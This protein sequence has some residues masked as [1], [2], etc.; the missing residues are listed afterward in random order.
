MHAE[1]DDL[2]NTASRG[3]TSAP[4]SRLRQPERDPLLR[5]RHEQPVGIEH[6]SAL[7]IPARICRKYFCRKRLSAAT[8]PVIRQVTAVLF[9]EIVW[10]AAAPDVLRSPEPDGA[11]RELVDLR[12]ERR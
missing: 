8:A 12:R 3:I 11:I 6:I 4:A 10:S 7:L 9:P 5:T 1:G 2:R